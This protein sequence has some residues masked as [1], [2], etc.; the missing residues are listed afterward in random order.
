[1][2]HD[3]HGII[4]LD[5]VAQETVILL[6]PLLT[7]YNYIAKNFTSSNLAIGQKLQ[8]KFPQ[9]KTAKTKAP[10]DPYPTPT[11]ATSEDRYI[12]L[13]DEIF[14]EDDFL[15][16][17]LH[18][19]TLFDLRTL[20]LQQNAIALAEG[21]VGHGMAKIDADLIGAN[22]NIIAPAS[23]GQHSMEAKAAEM[24]IAKISRMGRWAVLSPEY[25]TRIRTELNASGN[26]GVADEQNQAYTQ[27]AL[28]PFIGGFRVFESNALTDCVYYGTGHTLGAVAS[29][30]WV[31]S[32][33]RGDTEYI[34]V[35]DDILGMP[36]QFRHKWLTDP[37]EKYETKQRLYIGH[38]LFAPE[39]AFK[40]VAA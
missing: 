25:A 31:P 2:T 22:Q 14:V 35:Q 11:A 32:D 12:E 15:G 9:P 33:L 30:P 21:V 20:Y 24:D 18:S 36:L 19:T 39:T 37:V 3:D 16:T 29:L 34:N 4:S 17:D 8:V 13:Q 28:P 38:K 10:T 40:T 6:A 26:L 27:A 23:F 5:R 1:M 7:F